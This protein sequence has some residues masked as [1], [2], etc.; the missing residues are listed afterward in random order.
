MTDDMKQVLAHGD[1]QGRSSSSEK[2]SV[3]WNRKSSNTWP[4]WHKMAVF[5]ETRFS[6]LS[7]MDR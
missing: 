7:C 5:R 4:L 2:K 3:A 6:S 1:L